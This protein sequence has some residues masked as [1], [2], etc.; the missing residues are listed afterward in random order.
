MLSVAEVCELQP[1]DEQNAT[2]INPGFTGVVRTI[3]KRA[4]K[5]GGFFWPCVIAD[6]T[7]SATVEVSFFLVP[8]FSEGDLIEISGQGLRR[9]EYNGKAQ[10]AIGKATEVHVLGK[11]VHHEEQV[12]RQETLQP[13]LDG[14]KQHVNGQTVGMGIKEGLALVKFYNPEL[15]PDM[16]EFWAKVHKYASGA[17]RLG[18]AME[19]G[20]L[21]P[22]LSA[23]VAEAEPQ[24]GRED[25][26]KPKV[27][28]P[29]GANGEAF[30][31]ST[32]K[33]DDEDV[34]F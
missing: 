3:T 33:T 19:H 4:K 31:R 9:T 25:P 34:P 10:A 18:N 1:G 11:S 12:Q 21:T 16:A 22:A 30:P 6:T 29:A 27:K 24:G 2:W 15:K 17:V 13:A 8:K 28:P 20:N 14:T 32:K 5:A 26:P 7:G 23:P